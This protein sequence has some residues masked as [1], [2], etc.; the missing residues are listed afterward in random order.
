MITGLL[1]LKNCISQYTSM[2]KFFLNILELQQYHVNSNTVHHK[3]SPNFVCLTSCDGKCMVHHSAVNR[4]LLIQAELR[5]SVWNLRSLQ[6]V[7]RLHFYGHRISLPFCCIC[8]FKGCRNTSHRSVVRI[9]WNHWQ[10]GN[11]PSSS[12]KMFQQLL[13]KRMLYWSTVYV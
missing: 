9:T 1:N 8:L 3:L 12:N 11:Q 13:E 5:G 2:Q 4:Y 10:I 6:W 7:Q